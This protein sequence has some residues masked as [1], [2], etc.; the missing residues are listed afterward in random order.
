MFDNLASWAGQPRWAGAGFT[1][2]VMELAD[3]PGHPARA[4]AKKHKTAVEKW[5]AE[6]L[7]ARQVDDA[8]A[9]ARQVMLLLEG[10]LSL[11][12]IHG[13]QKYAAE[14]AAAAK[15]LIGPMFARPN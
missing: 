5:L 8:V 7:A 10:C 2:L 12:L 15:R 13:D 1:R 3:L 6:E 4:I 14:A 11:L 9:K